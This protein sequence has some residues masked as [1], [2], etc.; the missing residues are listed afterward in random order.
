[1]TVRQYSKAFTIYIPLLKFIL[2]DLSYILHIIQYYIMFYVRTV[3]YFFFF[4]EFNHINK[5]S[6]TI[7]IQY[8]TKIKLLFIEKKVV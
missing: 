1:M 4:K 8:N 6:N 3:F 7:Q 5:T 2:H